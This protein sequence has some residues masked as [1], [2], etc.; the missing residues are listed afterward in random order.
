[1]KRYSGAGLL[2]VL[3]VSVLWADDR[4][5]LYSD[6]APPPR[7]V[8]DRLN[9]K[10]AWSTFVPMDGRKDGFISIQLTD[11]Q[12]FVQSRSG[13]VAALNAET[14]RVLWHTTFGKG[15]QA[16]FPLAINSFAVIAVNGGTIYGLDRATGAVRWKF[17]Q[18]EGLSTAPVAD[19]VQMYLSTGSGRMY[20]YFLPLP[21]SIQGATAAPP[22]GGAPAPKPDEK[23][24]L[25]A[26]APYAAP[27]ADREAGG[28]RVSE[29]IYSWDVQTNVRLEFAPLVGYGSL[30]V[31]SPTGT[32]VVLS[33]F[34]ANNAVS[35]SAL[36]L[37]G[38]IAV[39]PGHFEDVMKNGQVE[40]TAY[41]GGQDASVYAL[42]VADARQRWRFPVGTAVMYPPA[43]TADDV[44]VTAER[45]GLY[46][47]SRATGEPQWRIKRGNRTIEANPDADRFLAVN[48]KFVY[49]ADKSGRLLVLD[50]VLGTEISSY[51][52]RDFAFPIA[53][54]M[55]DRLYLAANNGLI[56]CLHDKE[57][58]KAYYHQKQ[59]ASGLGRS[60]EDRI[61]L[62]KENL[63]RKISHPGYPDPMPLREAVDKLRKTFGLQIF[64]SDRAFTTANLPPINDKLVN[65]PKVENVVLGDYI[66][67]ILGPA[68]ATFELTA[69]V[70]QVIPLK[71]APPADKVP[72]DKVP[73]AVPGAGDK[74][75]DVPPKP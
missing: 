31:A 68:G 53:N 18:P 9:L 11:G 2:V 28:V 33:K 1:M 60:P 3:A 69:D 5:K 71:A 54:D 27:P 12:M 8:L 29:P 49:A 42:S 55:S 39:Q 62:V 21:P 44:F 63:A 10:Q 36:K 56:V 15:Y 19:E 14:G 41:L 4:T 66:K 45:N 48:P 26:G 58:T 75:G 6:P 25:T 67:Q 74:P 73:P 43:A 38:A 20:S 50:R 13:M 70:L 32:V 52:T 46:R 61:R 23:T 30:L 7:E 72:A 17:R 37:D 57:Y 34:P 64:A 59:N 35:Q 47:L 16:S 65:V 40:E 24:D 22:G 51:D